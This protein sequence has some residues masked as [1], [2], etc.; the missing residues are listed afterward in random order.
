MKWILFTGTWKLT[1][2][3]VEN[4]VRQAVRSVIERGD[5]VLTGGATGVDYFAMDEVLKIDPQVTHLRVIIPARLDSYI[6]DYFMNWCHEPIIK[7]DIDKLAALLKKIKK[8]NPTAL[9][10]MP[11]ETITQEHYN[12][13]HDQEVMYSDEV[14]AFQ[15][16]DSTGTQDTIDKSAKAGLPITNHKKYNI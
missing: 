14:Y 9:L 8:A 13:R 10:E 2:K 15:V 11:Y 5:G 3:D 1:N 6:H 12:L 16:N 4:D 7:E